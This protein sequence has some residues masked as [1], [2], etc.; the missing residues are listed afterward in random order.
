VLRDVFGRK[1]RKKNER[2]LPLRYF[3]SFSF[4]FLGNSH[5]SRRHRSNHRLLTL[6]KWPGAAGCVWPKRT[7]R[8]TKEFCCLGIFFVLFRFS[9]QQPFEQATQIEP[10]LAHAG[11]EAV[12]CG[13][14]LAEK[15][16][17]RTKE[18]CCLGIFFR[19]LS[20]FSATAIRA[21]DTDRTTACSR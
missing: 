1:E 11:K 15:N 7:K 18:F 6:R 21:G 8:R 10:P 16:E 9:R 19:S 3:F 5:S 12:Y 20:I 14:C 13:M 17:R 4:V 2:V